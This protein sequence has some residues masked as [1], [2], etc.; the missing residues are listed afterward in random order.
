MGRLSPGIGY[1]PNAP[2]IY[3]ATSIDRSLH[4]VWRCATDSYDV[5]PSARYGSNYVRS[6]RKQSVWYK[7]HAYVSV[8]TLCRF[9]CLTYLKAAPHKDLLGD[10]DEPPAASPPL[11][12]QSAE[13]GNVKNQ[14]SSTNRSLETAKAERAN[15]ERQLTEQ[16]ALLSSLQ[17]QLSSAKA[18]YDTETKLLGTLKDRYAAQ[19]AEIQKTREELIHAESDLSAAKVERA[20]VEGGLLRDKEEVRDLQRKMHEVGAQIEANKA[21]LEKLKKE[22]KQ[23]KGLLA[24]AKKQLATREAEKAKVDKEMEEA[25]AEL[26]AITQEREAAEAELNKEDAPTALTNGHISPTP[27]PDPTLAF[28][29]AQPLP[30]SM[31][32][33]PDVSPPASKSTN[34]FERLAMSSSPRPESP[35]LPFAATSAL[36]TPQT[37]PA[38]QE[39]VPED[40]F[41]F[42]EAFS[43]PDEPKA[44]APE[45]ETPKPAPVIPAPL[46]IGS[47]KAEEIIS[48]AETDFFTTPPTTATGS[49]HV[50]TPPRAS[51]FPALDNIVNE[52]SAPT[53]IG[54]P[55]TATPQ[56]P[57]L[58][59][60]DTDLTHELK[61]IEE[62][63]S[64]SDSDSSDDDD[65]PLTSV[66]AKLTEHSDTQANGTAASE[67]SG[68][69]AFDDSFGVSGSAASGSFAQAS[70]PAPVAI[71]PI[72]TANDMS[73][74]F[75][76]PAVGKEA[77]PSAPIPATVEAPK[78]NGSAMAPS[79]GVSEFDQA[80]GKISS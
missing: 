20:E 32:T 60:G 36:P 52:D 44:E 31:P 18:A 25:K 13:I 27:T 43:A 10:D 72:S 15:L 17:T 56:K 3:S 4:D 40:P 78:P 42:N 79:A 14:L 64:D 6:F 75:E 8:V 57:Q 68:T 41:G 55:L 37:A 66:K 45:P 69:S 74:I 53:P 5:S 24:I 1:C 54:A 73:T 7:R 51:Q 76:T 77:P 26:Q 19:S 29:A 50:I 62:S 22:A 63:D 9:C 21:E 12:D 71:P 30:S 70:E 49:E 33:S 58:H 59:E 47:P 67:A 28:A 2:S 35:F 23:Q 48:P 46:S 39:A 11:Q 61:E 38:V 34:P 16:A 65:E 80:L